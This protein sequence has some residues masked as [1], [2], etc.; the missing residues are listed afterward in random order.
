MATMR[1][2]VSD[3]GY[4]R[5]MRMSEAQARSTYAQKISER[6]EKV[7]KLVEKY[8]KSKG[9]AFGNGKLDEMMEK[10]SKKTTN[11]LMFLE[12]SEKQAYNNPI[13]LQNANQEAT[14]RNLSESKLVEAMQ[15]GGS[16]ALMLP[17]DIVKISRIGY[18]NAVAQD[19]FDVWGMSSMK[20]SL[21]KLE[22]TIGSTERGSTV[23][24]VAYEKYGEGRY[25]TTFEKENDFVA[26][27]SN[28]TFTKSSVATPTVLPFKVAIILDGSQIAVDDGMGKLV[29]SLLDSSAT[30][31]VNYTTGATTFTLT[32][33]PT[34]GASAVVEMLYAFDFENSSTFDDTGSVLLNLVEYN[35]SA[36]LQPLAIEW[37][38][39]TED[40]MQSKLGLSAKDMLI[41]G[42]GDV[43]RKSMDERLITRGMQ[44]SNWG[45]A[46]EFDT[47]FSTAGSDSSYE[48]AQS[49]INA[50]INAETKTYDQLGRMADETNIVCDSLSYSYLTKHRR[51]EAE[52]PSSKVGI[53][54]VGSLDG[55]GVYL[56]PKTV[57]KPTTGTG[58]MYLF[59]KSTQGQN[60]DAPISVG[61]YGSGITTNPVE[62]KNFNSQMGLGIYSDTKINNKYFATS[63][64]LKNLSSNS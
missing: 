38:R 23:G 9:L 36:I 5:V 55:R 33:A 28:K 4:R 11:L 56:A 17:S 64:E 60:V 63:V 24:D 48:H 35:F 15:T 41:A 46:I 7:N 47:D 1:N 42:A 6:E 21:Y 45:T 16:M 30:N 19:I 37:T 31:T 59:G 40:L 43:F 61:T 62:L 50:I 27:N 25:P 58:K 14:I 53:F 22:T 49:V 26:S 20:D 8:G 3:K 52:T 2:N 39:F 51:F 29:G 32:T 34:T 57:I 10:D 13:L 44:A 54:K 12:A 18:T